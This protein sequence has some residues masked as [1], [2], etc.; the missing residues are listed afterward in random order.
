MN[1]NR[2]LKLYIA[3]LT[4]MAVFTAMGL[5]FFQMI[6]RVDRKK[7][8]EL[9]T[10]DLLQRSREKKLRKNFFLDRIMKANHPRH[11]YEEVYEGG[12]AWCRGMMGQMKEIDIV[13]R[14]NVKL[15]ARY[16]K[17]A[18]A[19]RILILCH[20]YKGTLFGDFASDA[21]YLYEHNCSLLFIDQRG[22]GDSGGEYI[23]FGA[24]ERYDIKQWAEYISLRNRKKLPVYLFGKSLGGA[25]VLLA[26][27]LGLPGDVKGIIDDCG[28]ASA[29]SEFEYIASKW[30][31]IKWIRLLLF[32]LDILCRLCAGFSLK[33]TNTAEALSKNRLPVLIFHGEDDTFVPPSNSFIN[34]ERCTA[35]CELV[36]ISDAAHLCCSYREPELYMEKLFGFFR[37]HE[38]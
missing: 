23:C 9:S 14:D 8:E 20:G 3:A 36:M 19:K 22:C 18:D 25:S 16:L 38:L 13:S 15:H 26:S 34:K 17:A 32:R 28:F 4:G 31:H 11:R 33:E 1:K 24:K 29:T 21:K 5:S 10:A 7:G 30:F 12:K 2:F 6:F 35:E 27:G 37:K